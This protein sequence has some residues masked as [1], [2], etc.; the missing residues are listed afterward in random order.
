[1]SPWDFVYTPHRMSKGLVALFREVRDW[2][3]RRANVGEK[4]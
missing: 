4:S 1:M 3:R 2:L